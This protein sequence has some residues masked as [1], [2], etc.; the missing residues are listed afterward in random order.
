MNFIDEF[1]SGIMWQEKLLDLLRIILILLTAWIVRRLLRSFFDRVQSKLEDK[2][3]VEGEPATETAKRVGTIMKLVRQAVSIT[4]WGIVSLIVLRELGVNIGPILASAGILGLAIGFGAQNLVKDV[5][6]GFFLLLENQ[7]R[8]GDVAVI[9]GTGGLVEEVNFRTLV[10][11]DLKGVVH[12]FPNG[13][14][15]SLS[16]M[17]HDWSAYLFE[18]GVA[19]KE[20]TDQVMSVMQEVADGMRNDEYYGKMILEDL[21]LYGVDKFD[22]SAVIIKA[23]LK[24]KPI[25]QWEVGRQ[26]LGRLKK[27]FDE[28]GIEIPFPHQTLYFGKASE[29]FKMALQGNTEIAGE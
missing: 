17:T 3:Q 8:V 15:N 29:P 20:D 19:Y 28:R 14:I 13:S 7:V 9:N 24:T 4:F 6:A 23:R 5:I 22:S 16:N 1:L 11:R 2:H 10:L 12:V 25:K 18:I 26:F 27:A 21:E